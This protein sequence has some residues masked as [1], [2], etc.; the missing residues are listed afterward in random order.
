MCKENKDIYD[1]LYC[2]NDV[3]L[4]NSVIE[5]LKKNYEDADVRETWDGIHGTRIAFEHQT[6]LK[7]YYRKLIEEGLS[8]IS[9]TLQLELEGLKNGTVDED[10]SCLFAVLKQMKKEKE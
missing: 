7:C 3:D 10:K 1:L 5:F 6:D 9:F 4:K 2:E 8:G